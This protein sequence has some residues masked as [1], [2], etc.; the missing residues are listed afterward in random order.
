MEITEQERKTL[1]GLLTKIINK[2]KF[3]NCE[4]EDTKYIRYKLKGLTMDKVLR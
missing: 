3:D 2:E 1:I 4:I